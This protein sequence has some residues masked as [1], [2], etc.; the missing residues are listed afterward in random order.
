MNIAPAPSLLVPL[1]FPT[2]AQIRDPGEP[3]SDANYVLDIS[4]STEHSTSLVTWGYGQAVLGV[5][6]SR[7]KG[8]AI[9][10]EHGS[11]YIF[12]P[13]PVT[14]SHTR[15]STPSIQLVDPAGIS[16]PTS[17]AS[18]SR[19]PSR[20][21]LPASRSASPSS[22]YFNQTFLNISPRARIV[23]GVSKEQVEAP[24][25]YVDYEDE[26]DKL[27]GMLK[28]RSLRDRTI[29]DTLLPSFD[30]GVV[31]E[32]SLPQSASSPPSIP[33]GS[34]LKRKDEAKSLL[35]AM[36]S[37]T[38]SSKSMSS[39]PSPHVLIPSPLEPTLPSHNLSLKC[40][41]FPPHCG[42]GHA[43]SDMWMFEESNLL[44]ALQETGDISLFRVQD[45]TRAAFVHLNEPV[46]K[47]TAK[48]V[49]KHLRVIDLGEK[50][51]L[52]LACAALCEH[53]QY[54]DD[55]EHEPAQE[56][57]LVLLELIV[58]EEQG[59]SESKLEVLGEWHS[60]GPAQCANIYK[61][62]TGLNFLHTDR[63]NCINIQS[64]RILPSFEVH[65]S[66]ISNQ[67]VKQ[68][69]PVSLAITNA[70]KATKNKSTED[71]TL[72]AEKQK[73]KASRLHLGDE[74]D[75]GALM[76]SGP[77]L[78][79]RS[80]FALGKLWGLVWSSSE[81][82]AFDYQG[83]SI[84]VLFT[85]TLSR[86]KDVSIEDNH[87]VVICAVRSSSISQENG[88]NFMLWMLTTTRPRLVRSST[89]EGYEAL[90]CLSMTEAMCIRTGKTGRKELVLV[91]E[92]SGISNGATVYSRSL[93]KALMK[94]SHA[95]S[96]RLT[97][98]LPLELNQIILGYSD[99]RIRLSSL[100]KLAEKAN[101]SIFEK[102]SDFPLDGFICSLH[103]VRNDR[104]KERFVVGGGDDGSIGTW[105]LDSLKLCA[106]WTVFLT[107]LVRV[108]QLQNEK[109][110]PLRGCALC[111]S[112]DGTI[113]VFVIDGFQFLYLIP[114][115]SAPLVRVCING[116]DLLLVYSD[117][118]ARLW[119]VRTRELW[120]STTGEKAEE[121]INQGGWIDLSLNAKDLPPSTS[122]SALPSYHTG[123]DS[124]C[125]ISLNL[126]RF[127]KY[128][129]ITVKSV[130]NE[131][132][133][134]SSITQLRAILSI[135]LTPGL[136]HDVD[137]ICEIKL[138]IQPSSG[139]AGYGC[140]SSTSL[141]HQE[142]PRD[143][144]CIS[145]KISAARALVLVALLK[146]LALREELYEDCQ[147]VITFYSTSLAQAVGTSFQPPDISFLS[148]QWFESSNEIKQAARLL[149]DAGVTRLSDEENM[150]LV[151]AWQHHL[152]CL[153]P[154]ADK[155]SARAALALF[156]CGFMAIEKYSL[157]ST[158]SLVDISKSIALYLHDEQSPH[159]SLAIDLC[160]RGF[161]IWQ[162][163]VDAM[164]T[165]RALCS[166]AT[167]SRKE[168]ISAQNAGPQARLA[169]LQIASS[170]TPL[171]MTTLTLDILNPRN[172][173]HRKSIMQL[174][175]FLIR[176]RPLVL[177]HNLPRLMEAVVKSLDPNSTSSR[178][179]V[180]DTATEILGH[181]VKTFPT[182]DF[183]MATQRLAVGTS[184][185]AFIMY[186]LKTATQLYVLEAHKKRPAAC[187]FSPD[188]RR[189]VT[190]SLEECAVLVWKVG[191][192]FTNFFNPGAPPRQGH[193]G[194]Q[195]FKTLAFNVGDEANMTI[196]AT[197]EWVRFEWPADRSVKLRIRESTLTFST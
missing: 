76:S 157:M 89:V 116:D 165:L 172:L 51:K 158:S 42:P 192:S 120:R 163:Y 18:H 164:E 59:L 69:N 149:F 196:A 129:S 15:T 131:K 81:L 124:L 104:T 181:V 17:P 122:I 145:P 10:G 189:L 75:V 40:H 4:C 32:K 92:D 187:S 182:V 12:H 152:P 87:F 80:R 36:N 31:I 64:I 6:D 41:V 72:E 5:Q 88:I 159:R 43:I 167:N 185:G 38:I 67:G 119:G 195:P 55:N 45:G 113:A 170:N 60:E 153:Q 114:G 2:C 175:A 99:G 26:P 74:H 138:G 109:A 34:F 115:S 106:R 169:V 96:N 111:V 28:S 24:K 142:N 128:I 100:S 103:L 144:W 117:G 47:S 121:L 156:V 16:R 183:H 78:G 11:I 21:G 70:F 126:E 176:K 107:P 136:S 52:I 30:K 188:G 162:H 57:R 25:N 35:S 190:V 139:F 63:E 65:F 97:S 94:G 125:T 118:C 151:D 150:S 166:L 23:S 102:T 27:K 194:S 184:E 137:E 82:T 140:Y 197:L 8:A 1:T 61:D 133:Q 193:G 191:S 14:P 37:P 178:D 71:I 49:W 3:S 86:I 90:R 146:A 56:S 29:A 123:L 48:S 148:R 127:L 79:L 93:W 105:S 50:I 77:F 143:A 130:A 68:P 154:T 13:P 132:T 91:N 73:E 179:A 180:L 134:G 83:N 155:E 171:F 112:E 9:G 19:R 58:S 160:S 54:E 44:L 66:I 135:V 186:D 39:P 20:S 168:N 85:L 53:S 33:S 161:H 147:T 110:G 46:P 95:H 141:F 174:V 177:Y 22:L 84:R 101:K 7:T 108:I 98:I 173:D 62:N